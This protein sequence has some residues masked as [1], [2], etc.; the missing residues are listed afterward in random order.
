MRARAQLSAAVQLCGWERILSDYSVAEKRRKEVERL[1][2]FGHG[3]NRS[4]D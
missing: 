4:Q 2:F 3:V 1:N